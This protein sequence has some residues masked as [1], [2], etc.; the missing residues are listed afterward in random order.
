[1]E[2]QF[3][4]TESED[5][6]AR[7]AWL[8][9]RPMKLAMAYWYS[10]AILGMVVVGTIVKPQNWRLALAYAL[11]AIA[12][13]TPNL[14][15]TRWRWHK[16]FKKLPQA[17]ANISATVDGR[18]VTLSA[19]DEQKTHWWAGFSQIY[20]SRRAVV[21]E[22]GD[23]DFLFLPKHAMSGAQLAELRRLATSAPNCKV[24]LAAP[25]G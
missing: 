22:K 7:L 16:Q 12:A 1:M 19:L 21:L 25:L 3:R 23:T 24:R 14:I 5:A 17:N 18:G 4:W 6:A 20:E 13:A 9:H 2:I 8:L 11:V 15:L 10:L